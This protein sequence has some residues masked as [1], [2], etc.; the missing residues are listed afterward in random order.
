MGIKQRL[1]YQKEQELNQKLFSAG[2]DVGFQ[3]ACDFFEVVLHDP[4]IMGKDVFGADRMS[5]IKE[6]VEECSK[7]FS[8]AFTTKVEADILQQKLDDKIRPIYKEGF[9]EFPDRYPMLKKTT[10]ERARSNWV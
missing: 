9:V 7:I 2:Q 1:K 10:Y 6:A 8:D 4:D 3:Q 5:K